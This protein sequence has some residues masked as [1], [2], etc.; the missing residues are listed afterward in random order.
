MRYYKVHEFMG[1]QCFLQHPSEL[2]YWHYHTVVSLVRP[3]V[4]SCPL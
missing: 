3:M 4:Q 1:K 2:C